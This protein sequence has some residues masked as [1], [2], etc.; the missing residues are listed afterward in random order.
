[1]TRLLMAVVVCGLLASERSNAFP[2]CTGICM[3]PAGT[4]PACDC[5]NLNSC[6]TCAG[7]C[8]GYY[9]LCN[10][11]NKVTFPESNP[12]PELCKEHQP[13]YWLYEC[14]PVAL[15]CSG[16]DECEQNMGS[17][18]GVSGQTFQKAILSGNDC[19]F[20]Q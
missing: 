4:T 20:Q 2:D 5:T 12:S 10:L 8:N 18:L 17:Q 16:S 14:E 3:I 19:W 9:R 7:S 1:M 13:C 6:G 15:N 11:Q